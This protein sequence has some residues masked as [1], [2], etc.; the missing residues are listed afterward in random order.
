MHDVEQ[1]SKKGDEKSE[2]LSAEAHELYR[3]FFALMSD[4]LFAYQRSLLFESMLVDWMIW[5]VY[6]YKEIQGSHTFA[7]AGVT[8]RDGWET[9]SKRPA[10]AGQVIVRFLTA[11]HACDPRGT[12][13]FNIIRKNV[14]Q[15]VRAFKRKR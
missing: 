11:I 9:W 10:L 2:P 13:D 5:R 7:V 15:V 6:A 3:Q 4:Q 14:R 12:N 8:Y 1:R